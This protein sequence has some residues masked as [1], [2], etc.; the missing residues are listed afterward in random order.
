MKSFSK[1]KKLL[2]SYKSISHFFF[3]NFSELITIALEAALPYLTNA[4]SSLH[5]NF[6]TILSS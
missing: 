1:N 6:K 3:C 4:Q 2:L 5:D